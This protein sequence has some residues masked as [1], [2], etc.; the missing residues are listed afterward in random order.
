MVATLAL[1]MGKKKKGCIGK[2]SRSNGSLLKELAFLHHASMHPKALTG[3]LVDIINNK[4][5]PH[6]YK[7][8][9]PHLEGTTPGT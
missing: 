4:T 3:Y 7:A 9:Q 5:E 8:Q 2:D 1:L 6:A